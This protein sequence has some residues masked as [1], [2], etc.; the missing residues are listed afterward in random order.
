MTYE[1]VADV[2]STLL[3]Y[4]HKFFEISDFILGR[5]CRKSTQFSVGVLVDY[6]KLCMVAVQLQN[7]F[8]ISFLVL[9]KN[10]D[11]D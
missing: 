9:D 6:V 7:S 3:M 2:E 10:L 8:V 5:N 1:Y 4:L 11:L